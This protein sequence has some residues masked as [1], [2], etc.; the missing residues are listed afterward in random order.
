MPSTI[1]R[2]YFNSSMVRLKAALLQR[3]PV[4]HPNFNSSMVRLKEE[5][6]EWKESAIYKF[7]FLNGAIKS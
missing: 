4:R 7:Q 6:R 5:V 1:T 3:H 2:C